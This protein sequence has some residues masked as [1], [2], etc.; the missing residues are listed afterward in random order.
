MA[1]A[2]ESQK[3]HLRAGAGH[4]AYRKFHYLYLCIWFKYKHLMV[5][6]VSHSLNKIKPLIILT[7]EREV[8]KI[9]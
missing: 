4:V 8:K 5:S 6:F 1:V 2:L 3:E 7:K 9:P